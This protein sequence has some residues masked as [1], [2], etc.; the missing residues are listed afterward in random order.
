LIAKLGNSVQNR[1]AFSGQIAGAGGT[2]IIAYDFT[3]LL[4]DYT[5]VEPF[6]QL[7]CISHNKKEATSGYLVASQAFLDSLVSSFRI[8]ESGYSFPAQVVCNPENFLVIIKLG[9]RE[10]EAGHELAFH[11]A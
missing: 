1:Q 2:N 7:A 10:M 8:S 6:I 3:D 5:I 11:M 9:W 4:C